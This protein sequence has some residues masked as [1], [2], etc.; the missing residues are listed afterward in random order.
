MSKLNEWSAENL[1]RAAK[2]MRELD[3]SANARSAIELARREQDVDLAREKTKTAQYEA[4]RSMA[5]SK[6][7]R[8]RAEEQRRT[9][10]HRAHREKVRH[11]VGVG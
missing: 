3:A 8:T 9:L 7:E 5:A 2:F 10:D 11:C 6:T 4:E 1:E